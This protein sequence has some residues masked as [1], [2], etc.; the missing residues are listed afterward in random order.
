MKITGVKAIPKFGLLVFL[1]HPIIQ[2][3]DD[4]FVS[5]P[6]KQSKR[7]RLCQKWR[8]CLHSISSFAIDHV[9]LVQCPYGQESTMLGLAK[10]KTAH[11]LFEMNS[12]SR[13]HQLHKQ[14]VKKIAHLAKVKALL[15]TDQ[16]TPSSL[17]T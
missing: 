5:N 12:L 17:F 8:D 11:C 3:N 7:L 10:K 15:K 13:S 4:F 9:T 6:L 2:C 14:P 1:G 16:P